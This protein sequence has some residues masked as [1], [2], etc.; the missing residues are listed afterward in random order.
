MY[1]FGFYYSLIG[2]IIGIIIASFF[3]VFYSIYLSKKI[4]IKSNFSIM[5]N[6]SI[7]LYLFTVSLFNLY[8]SILKFSYLQ[9]VLFN[10]FVIFLLILLIHVFIGQKYYDMINQILK[11]NIKNPVNYIFRKNK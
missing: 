6:I 5:D 4:G 7:N 11:I 10:I 1:Y 8:F 9:I 2:I 3:R